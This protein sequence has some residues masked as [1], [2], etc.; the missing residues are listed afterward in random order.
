ML[1]GFKDF[2]LRGNVIE[3]AVGVIIGAA[4][5]SIVTALTEHLIEP[6]INAMGGAEVTGLGFR[7]ISDNSSTYMDF[8]A[9]ITAIINFLLVAAVV[10]FAIVVPMN[11]LHA[12]IDK[13]TGD[14][15]A[16]DSADETTEKELLEDIRDLLA[17][18]Q[19]S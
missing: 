10:Y 4:F 15:D 2:I 13:Q 17:Q 16:D 19:D 6:L 3:L 11:K 5:T 18:Q 14:K 12:V 8:A 9:V 7:I 1:K